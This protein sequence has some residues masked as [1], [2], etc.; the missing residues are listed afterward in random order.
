[1]TKLRALIIMKHHFLIA[2]TILALGTFQATAADAFDV[3]RPSLKR[4]DDQPR[5]AEDQ[6]KVDLGR[7]LFYE[8]RISLNNTMSCNTCHDLKRYGVDGEGFSKG[9]PGERVGR[10]SPTVYNA[11]AHIAQFWDGRAATVEEQAKGPILAGKEM[12]MPNAA[13]VIK[14]LKSFPEYA[15]LFKAAFPRSADSINYEHVGSAIGAFERNLATPSR[16]DA[17]LDGKKDA[18]STA[19]LAGAQTFVT[20]S[21]ITC[22]AGT[23]VGG[24]AYMKLGLINPWPNQKDQGRFDLTKK[25]DDK[26]FFKVP[27]LRNIAETGPYFHDSSST[28]LADAIKRMGKHQLG[29][30]L[31]A[32]EVTDLAAFLKALTGPLPEAYIKQQPFSAKGS[33]T[34]E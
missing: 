9:V 23:L 13:E 10:N 19:E 34:L 20:K 16:W 21:C 30:D 27:S 22:H 14:R 12:A 18:L 2:T 32:K 7:H 8:K 24:Q 1:M 4:L 25:A 28:T 29:L 17:F 5:S 11:Y 31:T 15:P 33:G 3:L 6:A 26:M